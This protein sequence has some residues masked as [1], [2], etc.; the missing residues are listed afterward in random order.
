M[1]S[2]DERMLEADGWIVECYSPFEISHAESESFAKNYAAELVVSNIRDYVVEFNE[3]PF[4]AEPFTYVQ[5]EDKAEE[6]EE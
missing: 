1:N 5:A 6:D 4:S 2:E 3:L